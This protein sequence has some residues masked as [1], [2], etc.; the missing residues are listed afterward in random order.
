MATLLILGSK[1][2][3]VLPPL[4]AIDAVA[5]ANGSGFSAACHGLPTPGFTVMSAIL[6]VTASG[7]Q[8]LEAL[9]GLETDTL[10]FL[11]RPARGGGVRKR[12]A[13]AVQDLRARPLALKAR[14]RRAEYRYRRFVVRKPLE[15][16][17]LLDHFCGHD[18]EVMARTRAKH[19]STGVMTLLI[20]MSS[21]DYDHFVLSGFSFELTHAYG[22]NPEIDQRGTL[23]SRH[24]DTDIA[25]L[26]AVVAR[27][28]RL[29]TTEPRVHEAAGVPLLPVTAGAVSADIPYSRA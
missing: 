26:R 24:A 23:A 22:D 21:G 28:G 4:G 2:D 8:T 18:A 12:V 7:Q 25:V 14:L 29:Y 11:P 3:P 5:C 1:P 27:C 16:R 15:N 13:R 9:R 20:G 10:Y 6:A 19:P 17:L